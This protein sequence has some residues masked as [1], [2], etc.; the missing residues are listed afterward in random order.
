MTDFIILG[1][2][3]ARKRIEKITDHEQNSQKQKPDFAL[4]NIQLENHEEH[5]NIAPKVRTAIFQQKD[6]KY[7]VAIDGA[8]TEEKWAIARHY[9]ALLEEHQCPVIFVQW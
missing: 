9:Q 7:I 4:K 2:L 8:C 3:D 6:T 1:T 5:N